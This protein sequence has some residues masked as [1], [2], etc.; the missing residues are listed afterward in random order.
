MERTFKEIEQE[1]KEQGLRHTW[2]DVR[3]I[4]LDEKGRSNWDEDDCEADAYI[5]CV[6]AM[7]EADEEYLGHYLLVE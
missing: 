6:R 1:L 4:Q 5:E 2:A 7:D 3:R